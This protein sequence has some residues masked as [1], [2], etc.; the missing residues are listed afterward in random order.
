MTANR[1]NVFFRFIALMLSIAVMLGSSSV[2]EAVNG[3]AEELSDEGEK[4]SASLTWRKEDNSG[5]AENP[6]VIYDEESRRDYIYLGI[7]IKNANSMSLMP[8]EF[9]LNISG[10]AGLR[11]D[12]RLFLAVDDPVFAENWDV[13]SMAADG[14]SYVLVNKRPITKQVLSTLH[15]EI[16]SRDAVALEEGNDETLQ[17]FMR[18]ISADY[19]INRYSRDSYGQ[20][21]DE[22]GNVIDEDG[23]LRDAD[24]RYARKDENGVL[25]GIIPDNED[26]PR[27]GLLIDSDGY[28]RDSSGNRLFKNSD[29]DYIRVD[30][31]GE[32][33][34]GPVM[35]TPVSGSAQ[36][37]VPV[38]AYDGEP[39]ATNTLDFE[40][41]SKH[42]E[43]D[44]EVSGREVT[45]LEA[46]DLN[47]KYSWY[48]FN[49]KLNQEKNARGV[50]DSD[51]FIALDLP[52]GVTPSDVS[53]LDRNGN[54]VTLTT[55]VINGVERLGFY[56]Y[57]NRKGDIN[58]YS[59]NYRVGVLR[60]KITDEPEDNI[61][62]FTGV[63]RVL[64]NDEKESE[65]KDDTAKTAFESGDI[66][67]GTVISVPDYGDQFYDPEH[68]AFDK[69]N[70]SKYEN[71]NHTD[72]G[73][74]TAKKLLSGNLFNGQ[75]VTYD[76]GVSVKK[77]TGRKGA[78]AMAVTSADMVRK[79]VSGDISYGGETIPD[80]T[81]YDLVV[82]DDTLGLAYA[83]GEEPRVLDKGE[84]TILN[85]VIPAGI[86]HASDAPD[87]EYSEG[88]GYDYELYVSNDGGETFAK[89][90]EGVTSKTAA[91]TV[92]VGGD[93]FYLVIKDLDKVVD[94][95]KFRTNIKFTLD[96]DKEENQIL[97][98]SDN[99]FEES[100]ARVVNYGYMQ[101][102][103]EKDGR[104]Y[105]LAA[106]TER[107]SNSV[108]GNSVIEDTV[109]SRTGDLESGAYLRR[110]YSNVYLRTDVTE[111]TSRTEFTTPLARGRHWDDD[112]AGSMDRWYGTVTTKGTL[113]SENPG[114]LK[115]FT[116]SAALPKYLELRDPTLASVRES[117]VFSGTDFGNKAAFSADILTSENTTFRL[118]ENADGTK[119]I[120]V[121][122]DF[123]G[124]PL[125]AS[126]LTSVEFSYDV[127][128]ED[129]NPYINRGKPF[130][131]DS[132]TRLGD[133]GRKVTVGSGWNNGSLLDSRTVT[134]RADSYIGTTDIVMRTELDKRVLTEFSSGLYVHSSMVRGSTE[135]NP[136]DYTYRLGFNIYGSENGS[137][138][139]A[140][141]VDRLEDHRKNGDPDSGYNTQWRGTLRY[142]DI[143]EAYDKMGMPENAR[144]YYTT[145]ENAYI[146]DRAMTSEQAA[147]MTAHLDAANGWKLMESS[148]SR[149]WTVPDSETEDVYA[150]AAV[151]I[152]SADTKASM[153]SVGGGYVFNSAVYVNMEAP[154]AS[155][156]TISRMAVNSF[157][158]MTT[159]DAFEEGTS[160]DY[161]YDDSNETYVTLLN[162]LKIKKVDYDNRSKG[163]SGAKF[164]VLT[165]NT[166]KTMAEY[167]ADND[168]FRL[169][170]IG[171]VQY[172]VFDENTY[173]Y[174]RKVISELEVDPKGIIEL[175]LPPGFY[176]I[177]ETETPKGY[178]GDCEL[179]YLIYF[180]DKGKATLKNTYDITEDD[181]LEEFSS[182]AML[183]D[184]TD[185]VQGLIS[186]RNRANT[187]GKAEF[188]KEDSD[189]GKVLEGAEFRLMR[190]D[191]NGELQTV[192]VRY[193]SSDRSYHCDEN[194]TDTI[195]SDEDGRFAVSGLTVGT[196]ALEE[197]KVPTGYSEPDS[198]TAFQVRLGNI[199]ADGMVDLTD[200]GQLR[201]VS[202]IG[203]KEIRSELRLVKHDENEPDQEKNLAGARYSL[204]QLKDISE[205]SDFTDEE[206]FLAAAKS[207]IYGWDGKKALTY[208]TKTN[209][210]LITDASGAG[211]ID[212][213]LFGTYFLY[214]ELAPSGYKR[215]N[216]RNGYISSDAF[217]D[218]GIFT[219]SAESAASHANAADKTFSVT[220]N[221]V[222]KKGKAQIQKL[223]AA[224]GTP[225]AGARFALLKK[226]GD[227][228]NPPPLSNYDQLADK[229][230]YDTVIYHSGSYD[231]PT[232]SDGW[233]RVID[234]LD[235]G[236]Y[237]FKEISAPIGFELSSETR[238]FRIS[239]KTSGSVNRLFMD[240]D[241]KSGSAVLEKYEKDR[242]E[243]K[244]AGAKFGLLRKL[245][246][247]T[248]KRCS[249]ILSGGVYR[250]ADSTDAGAVT[251]L[252]TDADGKISVEG[253]EWGT[254]EFIETEPPQGYAAAVVESFTVDRDSCGSQIYRKC[255]EPRAKANILIDKVL[256]EGVDYSDAFG[257]PT[258]IFRITE[259]N[260]M[261][262]HTPK[263]KGMTYTEFM[264]FAEGD[265]EGHTSVSVAQGVYMIEEV[266]V[267][268][269]EFMQLRTV[270]SD[271][272]I[273]S[274][275][276]A[277]GTAQT[278]SKIAYCDLREEPGS[279]TVP[280]YRAE[281][282]NKIERY[283]TLSHV[284]AAQNRFPA[285]N[286]YI[287]GLRAVYDGFVPVSG[288]ET[289]TY[290]IPLDDIV[291]SRTDSK[292]ETEI[293]T[294]AQ[295]AALT[296][297]G[298]DGYSVQLVN[299][300][301]TYYLEVP[302]TKDYS[303]AGRSITV[304][305]GTNGIAA[306]LQISYEGAKSDIK[307][308]VTL[309]QDSDNCSVFGE[310][311][312]SADVIFTKSADTGDITS[313]MSDPGNKLNIIAPGYKFVC[314][315]YEDE[316]G[317]LTD[318][319]FNNEQEIQDFIFSQENEGVSAF[320]FVAQ[321]EYVPRTMAKFL[322]GSNNGFDNKSKNQNGADIK[323]RINWLCA[324]DDDATYTS[325][326]RLEQDGVRNGYP[327]DWRLASIQHCTESDYQRDLANGLIYREVYLSPAEGAADYDPEYPVPVKGYTVLDPATDMY[328]L[329]I[330]T[331]G[332]DS[333]ILLPS[334]CYNMFIKVRKI[335]DLSGLEYW[336]TSQVTN[337]K[338][339]FKD[340]ALYSN[341]TADTPI[342]MTPIQNWDTSSVTDM[343][344]M[345]YNSNSQRVYYTGF[346]L[347]NWD[348]S[349]VTKMNDMFRGS[350]NTHLSEIMFGGEL[351]SVTTMQ[352]I[353]NGVQGQVD[354]AALISTWKLKGSRLLTQG[355]AARSTGKTGIAGTYTT[356]DGVTVTINSSGQ[357]S[358]SN[359]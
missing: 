170:E 276:P 176:F 97:L 147:D 156:E 86:F 342:D 264:S 183:V 102:I 48:N 166:P 101:M 79:A 22:D 242:P 290:R 340:L 16:N 169:D 144:V 164:E 193:D 228:Q 250:I 128:A 32:P 180:D 76:L 189:S 334:N 122:F 39:V 287:T 255:E 72:P 248:S 11:R 57:K 275:S 322:V 286:R 225:L 188:T 326:L 257:T 347:S 175:N 7:N 204:Y 271:T 149:I 10:I 83:S 9:T 211:T 295:K 321:L 53:V 234:N 273:S 224:D 41:F 260:S 84:Y 52:E 278:D 235:W 266:S 65:Y 67:E 111:L 263:A 207:E 118:V 236:T 238:E 34:D 82:G 185:G 96:P 36:Y 92:N 218:E 157:S 6:Y 246:D 323:S 177:R 51:L 178:D 174:S 186:V 8:G 313:N 168:S 346:D 35:G 150:I 66:D 280:Q 116:V 167:N 56:E 222:R 87:G 50:H 191:D 267:S 196:Y 25:L 294:A 237:Y 63:S 226:L 40:Y 132:F 140:V 233:T 19:E 181:M 13:V 284:T 358:F 308:Y 259:I 223:S 99:T 127:Y 129:D 117:M 272:N 94:N 298:N 171:A 62:R 23:Y 337:M 73:T 292:D 38:L 187:F 173:T 353:F 231:F 159:I 160:D 17:H 55:Q 47:N 58:S 110:S 100:A 281:Y 288:A 139:E 265:T 301:G 136:S 315:Q 81:R 90:A 243:V 20:L 78:P 268:R 344:G 249:V 68:I 182:G 103:Y 107:Y 241:P 291:I 327:M 105:D 201:D 112:T 172:T 108:N 61:L 89:T 2:M 197:T 137:L 214:E 279:D 318:M 336:D 27:N 349:N 348:L 283:D 221:D 138:K 219:V 18:T 208:W 304:T 113:V 299:D 352:N 28:Y 230:S 312:T 24:G 305:D 124:N 190:Y 229:D 289:S 145:D 329:Y 324:R 309:R 184:D 142:V 14:S 143:G 319:I 341:T 277:A 345:F 69:S 297:T 227:T 152:T 306:E 330:F 4:Y 158:A 338:Q 220:H 252:I 300:G 125:L 192:G 212:E 80:S 59:A 29:G 15:W 115:K 303:L 253:L 130:R 217:V 356:A 282:S 251:E 109:N 350:Y 317:Q 146:T 333:K 123:T 77:T 45:A 119:T 269:Y 258:F 316:D 205:F 285:A 332:I 199:G 134:S 161:G 314:W 331:E 310:D 179:Y 213:V 194:G 320:T 42:D 343:E 37:G 12:G 71:G 70:G 335:K 355:N 311:E 339:M 261:T 98:R 210:E 120:E 163:L 148:D 26:D 244:L 91:Q 254:Y 325:S 162:T 33:L 141:L 60:S 307:K 203:N 75:V 165:F 151:L 30:E 200:E 359:Y 351:T 74:N 131:V 198:F 274:Y 85:V 245:A 328:T 54:P 154:E 256:P 262:D 43:V 153:D 44:I 202:V 95:K 31:N 114:T 1:R 3:F 209:K 5:N 302:N 135:E 64:Y 354:A 93:A 133:Q 21:L 121:D 357:M 49:V 88:D 46:E 239:A 293:L 247:G 232:D 296:Y 104:L 215:N 195:T 270:D 106:G 206:A 155:D 240:D 216:N 126:A